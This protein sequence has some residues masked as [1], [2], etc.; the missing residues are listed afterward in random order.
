MKHPEGRLVA[1]QQQ[2]FLAQILAESMELDTEIVL[3]HLA[4]SG[5][6]LITDVNEITVDAAAVMPN[7]NEYRSQLRAVPDVD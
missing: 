5:L 4:D 1:I 6:S 2:M 3:R 7:I